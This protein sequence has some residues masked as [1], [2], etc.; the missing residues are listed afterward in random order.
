MKVNPFMKY[1]HRLFLLEEMPKNSICAEI[2]VFEGTF[3]YKILEICKP[4][5]LHLID[6][7]PIS[8]FHYYKKSFKGTYEFHEIR[9]EDTNFDDNYFDWVYLDADHGFINTFVQLELCFQKTKSN[10]FIT[11]DDYNNLFGHKKVMLAVDIFLKKYEGQVELEY[12][13]NWQYKIKK[14]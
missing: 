8:K 10:G 14:Y 11:G 5:L 9:F 7:T 3:S 2:G 6:P 4:K 13:K 12:I 1:K